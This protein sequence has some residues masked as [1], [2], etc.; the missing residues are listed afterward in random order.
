[1]SRPDGLTAV[2]GGVDGPTARPFPPA[3]D[4]GVSPCPAAAR[5]RAWPVCGEHRSNRRKRP[6]LATL[7]PGRVR[8]A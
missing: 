4:R 6:V 1:M 8:A 3:V 7:S 2:V 5:G